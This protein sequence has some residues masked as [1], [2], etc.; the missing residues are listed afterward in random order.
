NHPRPGRGCPLGKRT[1]LAV[2]AASAMPKAA[3]HATGEA[4]TTA[5]G[6]TCA[7]IDAATH[8]MR[9]AVAEF[10]V[11]AIVRSVSAIGQISVIAIVIGLI[12]VARYGTAIG[13]IVYR[14]DW[15]FVLVEIG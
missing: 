5:V 15:T 8:A 14:P 11:S 13:R 3:T 10:A 7:M 12:S 9:E 4:A 2:P 6:E 1:A